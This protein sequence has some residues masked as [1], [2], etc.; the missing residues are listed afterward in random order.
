M[1]CSP[2]W[3]ICSAQ[4]TSAHYTIVDVPGIPGASQPQ[5]L[6]PAWTPPCF[7]MWLCRCSILSIGS[8]A[9]PR[10]MGHAPADARLTD[11]P[12]SGWTGA[13]LDAERAPNGLYHEFSNSHHMYGGEL[14]S[15][16]SHHVFC[17]ISNQDVNNMNEFYCRTYPSKPKKSG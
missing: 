1:T 15:K 4:G 5:R 12:A 11:V 14:R 17:Y 10:G 16:R 6:G 2:P 3:L 9:F 8:G 7:L 13:L